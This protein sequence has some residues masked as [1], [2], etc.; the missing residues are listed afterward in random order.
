[1]KEDMKEAPD[2][3]LPAPSFWPII[4]A[5]GLALIAAGVVSNILVSIVGIVVML[6]AIAGWTMENRA[7]GKEKGHE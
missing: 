1:M 7:A 3:H 5:F 6:A 4:L 2:I